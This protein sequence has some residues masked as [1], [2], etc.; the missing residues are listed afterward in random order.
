M[1]KTVLLEV[2]FDETQTSCAA[3]CY[4]LEDSIKG[5][6]KAVWAGGGTVAVAGPAKHIFEVAEE[7]T[8]GC[9]NDDFTGLYFVAETQEEADEMFKENDRGLCGTCLIEGMLQTQTTRI[10]GFV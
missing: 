4:R 10:Y 6:D 5:I 8:C 3:I 9:C 1:S 7:G 2:T